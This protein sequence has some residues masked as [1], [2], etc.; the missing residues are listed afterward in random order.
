MWDSYLGSEK[1]SIEYFLI[2]F[3]E[4]LEGFGWFICEDELYEECIYLLESYLRM[5]ENSG[6]LKV[7]VFFDFI[8]EVVLEKLKCWF[9]VVYK[10]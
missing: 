4:E 1:Y 9:F 8:D 7:E 6:F 2:F 10:D 5:L 3:V